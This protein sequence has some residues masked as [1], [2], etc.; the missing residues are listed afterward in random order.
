MLYTCH[1]LRLYKSVFKIKVRE[2]VDELEKLRDIGRQSQGGRKRRNGDMLDER[3]RKL[4]KKNPTK[5]KDGKMQLSTSAVN[6]RKAE[7]VKAARDIHGGECDNS[8]ATQ[9]GL[10]DAAFN[11]CKLLLL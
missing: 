6:K 3:A 11:R 5:I 10:L 4:R 9:I 1:I 7:T 2:A 8:E